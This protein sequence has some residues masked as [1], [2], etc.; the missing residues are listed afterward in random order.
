M[1]ISELDTPAV[2]IDLDR[3]ERNIRRAQ[4]QCARHGKAMRPHIKTHKMPQIARMQMEAGAMGITCAKLGEVEVMLEAGLK[5]ILLAY[6]IVGEAKL[7]RLVRLAQEANLTVA[8]DSPEVAEGI[9]RAVGR[10]GEGSGR[11][12]GA[13]VEIDTGMGR[14]GI[15]PGPE[16]VALCRKVC[17]LPG[18]RFRGLMT[19]QGWVRGTEAERAAQLREENDRLKRVRDDLAAAGIAIEEMSGGSTPTLFQ[20]HLLEPVTDNRAGTYVFNDVNTVSTGSVTWD[21]CAMCIAVTVV[22]TAVP[23]QIIVDGGSKTFTS[24]RPA[25]TEGGE[26]TH[27]YVVEDPE[28]QFVKMNEEH[29]YVKRDRSTKPHRI[30]DR[31]HIIPN[32]VCVAI[33]MHDEVYAHRGGEV[34]ETWRVAARGKVR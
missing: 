28:L 22:S 14:C 12:I 34:V 26:V 1:H 16:M 15:A 8:F 13:L 6:P 10:Y 9:S 18:L 30:G 31:L 4:E 33:N 7:Q 3:M 23:G 21:D 25:F 27:G 11:E 17:D 5:E 20:S 29:G 19:Y 32:H 2:L 24:D